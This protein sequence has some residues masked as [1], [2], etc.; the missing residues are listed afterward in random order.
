ML[1]KGGPTIC[2]NLDYAKL[3]VYYEWSQ[4]RMAAKFIVGG[5]SELFSNSSFSSQMLQAT[6]FLA[7]QK[8]IP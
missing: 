5:Y 8:E 7:Q 3:C 6:Q 4:R 2:N 1:N